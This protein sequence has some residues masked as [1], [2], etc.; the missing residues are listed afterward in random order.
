MTKYIK[1]TQREHI[2]KRS[3]TYIGSKV[4]EKTP[5]YVLK[6]NDLTNPRVVKEHVVNNK[7][8]I[9]LFDEILTNASDHAIRTGKVSTIK[10]DIEDQKISVYNDGPTIE[11]KKH[12]LEKIY[13]PELIFSHLLT[14]EN[15][16][17][18]KE[19]MVGGRNG[20]GSKLTNIFSKEFKVECFDG[21]KIYTQTTKNN[22]KDIETP[23]IKRK[24]GKSFTK[25]TYYPDY[26]QFDFDGL[27]EDLKKIMFKRCLD[28]K[29]YIKD[30]KVIVNSVEL[31][32]DKISDYM[33]LHLQEGQEFFF[34]TLPNGWEV[35]I[36]KST[37]HKFESNSIVNGI[38]THNGGSHVN[39]IAMNL[40]NRISSK[41]KTK[42]SRQEV[43]NKLHIFLIS[44]IPNPTFDTQTKETLTSKITRDIHKDGVVK[45]SV[46][47]KIMKSEIVKSIEDEL[48][49]KEKLQLKKMGGGKRNKVN[50]PKLH[51]AN[52][53]GTKDSQKCSLFLC[54]GDSATSMAVSGMSV[55][56]HDYYGAFPLKG[57]L[58]NVR[59]ASPQK[60]K[61]NKEIQNLLN[62]T[63]L[64]FTKKYENTSQ[65]RYGKI[66]IMTDADCVEENTKVVLE[67]GK[68]KKI[69]DVNKG[70][71]IK[72]NSGYK[73]VIGK[74][75]SV[76][77]K[78]VRLKVNG[79]DFIFG[80]NHKI[81]VYD[82]QKQKV[83]LKKAKE[84]TKEDLILKKKKKNL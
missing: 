60:I 79:K 11:I 81:P 62:V 39:Y 73:P 14:G 71:K 5:L 66:V 28:V 44:G 22:M 1:L 58:L 29:A 21:K 61:A 33:K 70:D 48:K 20:L 31:K 35:G 2:L 6:D 63:G 77:D 4:S 40:S 8:F 24:K 57:K 67:G 84:I 72:T 53:A 76:K 7:A 69:K 37:S 42:P 68:T 80:E 50:L 25:I 32:I 16:D 83:T 49:M 19:R 23:T 78:R 10:V 45:E 56:G 3:E 64:E 15:Y 46:V 51:D 54:E 30:V 27:T 75:Q 47:S 13:N 38:T 18:S 65:L 26:S 41:M 74:H 17:D 59:E 43:R 9:K 12:P 36:A 52:K 34:D 55:V 82:K